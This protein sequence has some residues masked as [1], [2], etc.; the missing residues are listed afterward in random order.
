LRYELG[1]RGGKNHGK[2]RG[3]KNWNETPTNAGPCL[4]EVVNE[5]LAEDSFSSWTGKRKTLLELERTI[6]WKG[7]NANGS[8]MM[9]LTS[10]SPPC[11]LL[12]CSDHDH[13]HEKKVRTARWC[14]GF[15]LG[16][17]WMIIGSFRGKKEKIRVRWQELMRSETS[18]SHEADPCNME[19]LN[20]NQNQDQ[21]F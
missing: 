3:R 1:V 11:F 5:V 8:P 2:N 20:Q 16:Q 4:S 21:H 15:P 13:P 9:V 12:E 14:D 10:R 6:E 19:H 17:Q 7:V 18:R